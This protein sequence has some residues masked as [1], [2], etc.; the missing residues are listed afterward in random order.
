MK[1]L[2]GS[3][4][5]VQLSQK[6]TLKLQNESS[7][8]VCVYHGSRSPIHLCCFAEIIRIIHSKVGGIMSPCSLI[9][10]Y[11][12]HFNACNVLT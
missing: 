8:D 4:G 1:F 9:V 12:R 6:V 7:V 2:S 5:Y 3:C 11:F 10:A